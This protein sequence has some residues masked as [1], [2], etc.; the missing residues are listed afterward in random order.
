ML[1]GLVMVSASIAA[2][3]AVT[4]AEVDRW[5]TAMET[6]MEQP[7]W[8]DELPENV[9][10]AIAL[11][12]EQGR[13]NPDVLE[14]NEFDA[15]RWDEVTERVVRTLVTL[16]T[17]RIQP[18]VWEQVQEQKKVIEEAEQFSE[19]QKEELI[20]EVDRALMAFMQLPESDP[21]DRGAVRGHLDELRELLG[22]S[23]G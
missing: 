1:A 21:E 15:E 6:M 7:E 23:A 12:Q 5:I 14:A 10:G 9:D 2:A 16:E 3:D 22:L 8:P 11:Y 18:K 17:A 4:E 13:E 20:Q 19:E